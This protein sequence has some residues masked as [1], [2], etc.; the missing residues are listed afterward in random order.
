MIQSP[1]R[2]RNTRGVSPNCVRSS[3]VK[4]QIAVR[5]PRAGIARHDE[6]AYQNPGPFASSDLHVTLENVFTVH[7]GTAQM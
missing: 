4:F 5:K 3:T 6:R 1:E 7:P 2:I